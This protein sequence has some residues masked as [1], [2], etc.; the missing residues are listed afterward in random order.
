[1]I[2]LA[3][4]NQYAYDPAKAV[5]I[6]IGVL[7][8]IFGAI[9]VHE[10]AHAWM[11]TRLGDPTAKHLGRLTLNPLAHIDAL[12]L[13]LFVLAG[14]GYGKPVPYDER[15]LKHDTDEIKI[16][17]AG[18]AVNFLL[19]LLLALPYRIATAF[20]IDISQSAAFV[21]LDTVVYMNL[22][23]GVFNLI[24]IPPLDGSKVLNYFLDDDAREAYQ[25]VGSVLLLVLVFSNLLFRGSGF[26]L[27]DHILTPLLH[28]A[29]LLVR[30]TPQLF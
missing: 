21:F 7:I 29:S 12:G 4:W 17:L 19:A 10:F 5:I 1:M 9:S 3:L 6:I 15:N 28:I 23:L 24:P 18:P 25:R 2:I 20:G 16:A 22:V 26:N 27:L 8:G 13:F 14:F 11:A 30:G